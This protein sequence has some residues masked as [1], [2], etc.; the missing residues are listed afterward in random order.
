MRK[1]KNNSTV[2][3]MARY[4]FSMLLLAMFAI[5]FTASESD[6]PSQSDD[7]P[8]EEPEV[9]E[10]DVMLRLF[11][12]DA[13]QIAEVISS[14]GLTLSNDI[15]AALVKAMGTVP[16]LTTNL[17]AFMSTLATRN[18]LMNAQYVTPGSELAE[19][20]YVMYIPV[21]VS[22]YGLR[23]IL[24][25]KGGCRILSGSGLHF[26][27][28]ANV[29]GVGLTLCKLSLTN[30]GGWYNLV[31]D[32]KIGQA[33]HVACV[34]RIPKRFDI[35][36]STLA[37]DKEVALFKGGVDVSLT[38]A[39][40]TEYVKASERS[41]G[42]SGQLYSVSNST[43]AVPDASAS[44]MSFTLLSE[45]NGILSF[46]YSYTQAGQ[47]VIGCGLQFDTA[48][49][50]VKDGSYGK[51]SMSI[52]NNLSMTGTIKDSAAF[53]ELLTDMMT[54]GNSLLT[55]NSISNLIDLL[56]AVCVMQLSGEG[57]SNPVPMLLALE[58]TD[59]L[60]YIMPKVKFADSEDYELITS[61]VDDET[62]ANL[63]MSSVTTGMSVGSAANTYLQ[64]FTKIM[65]MIPYNSDEWG[66]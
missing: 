8:T 38:M 31:S 22:A 15:S 37:N 52:L 62:A 13:R 20:G 33:Q 63:R 11:S 48:N 14:D 51:L 60:R 64:L 23:V 18:G 28:P 66:L 25:G 40:G 6:D 42:L 12:D 30:S 57:I 7:N 2:T 29:K 34:S 44:G 47:D 65:Q 4:C 58:Q 50:A 45:E 1:A 17:H 56:N 49:G 41:F 55:A 59:N 26:I 5:G 3:L 27:F 24:D 16:Q 19:M 46:N 35:T 32:A 9:T 43:T 53:Q 10:R 21:D 54:N 39:P 36:L 61:L